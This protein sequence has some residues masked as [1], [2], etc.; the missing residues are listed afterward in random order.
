M[1]CSIRIITHATHLS[2]DQIGTAGAPPREGT[3]TILRP[4][5]IQNSSPET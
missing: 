1:L 3:I 2:A 4:V 5:S